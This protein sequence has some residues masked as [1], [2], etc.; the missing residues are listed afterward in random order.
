MRKVLGHG[1]L[2]INSARIAMQKAE[3]VDAGKSVAGKTI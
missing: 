1:L 3:V 2:I